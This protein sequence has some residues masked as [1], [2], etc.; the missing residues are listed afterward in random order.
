MLYTRFAL[1]F[2]LKLL[3]CC[4]VWAEH[5]A[6]LVV[7]LA[8]AVSDWMQL[9]E[10]MQLTGCSCW[11]D[12]V[13]WIQLLS[14][15]SWLSGCSLNNTTNRTTC[16]AQ[17][18]QHTNSF[19][20]NNNANLMY[21]LKQHCTLTIAQTTLQNNNS[22]TK[23]TLELQFLTVNIAIHFFKG[24]KTGKKSVNFFRTPH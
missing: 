3:V 6:L 7:L 13:A 11:A 23:N 15:C 18:T 24:T 1:L 10:R 5:V 21:Y 20:L 9:A 14:G 4:V 22:N 2:K 16:S 8:D 19:S 12:A 17:T